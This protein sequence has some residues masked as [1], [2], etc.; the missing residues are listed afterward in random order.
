MAITGA[1]AGTIPRTLLRPERAAQ[2][3]GSELQRMLGKKT[4]EAETA[5]LDST[6]MPK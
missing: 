6:P 2:L 5:I 1:E 3:V 4:M